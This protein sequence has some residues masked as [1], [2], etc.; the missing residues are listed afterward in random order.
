M[1]ASCVTASED[2]VLAE[3]IKTWWD[4]ESY[5]SRCDVSGRSKDDEKALQMLEQ[6]TKFDGERYEVGLLWKRRNP[7]LPNN[8]SSALN[9]MKSLEY[10]LERQPELKKLYQDTIKVDVEKGFV[11]ILK[12]E[13]LE[14]T[15]MERQWYVPHHPEE[16]PN[17]P[18]KV[19]RVCNAASKFR[20]ISLNDNLLTGTDLL[21]NLIG[22]IFRFREQKIA[23]TADIE[24]MFLQV[25]VQQEDCKVLRFLWRDN[26]NE[27][28]KVYEYG[29]H[30]F[31]AKSL[32]T[33]ANYALQQVARDYAQESPQIFKLIMRNFYKDDFVKSVPSA[34]QAIEI[35][36]LLPAML[37]KGGF[38][39]TKWIS[40]CEQTM[41]S[42]DQDDKSPASSKTFEAQPT[43]PSILGLQW[44]VDADNLEVCR[45]MQKE[46]P[47]KITQRAVLSHVS[48]LFDSLGIVSPFTIRMR[49]LLK[50][51]WKENRQSWVKELIEENRHEFKK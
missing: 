2:D 51:I 16:N 22:I 39:L 9:Q 18:G 4:I 14:A 48:A 47:V 46:I 40:N 8:Y 21:Q 13:E 41:T 26:P 49:L 27:P 30:I 11:R 36:K 43:S 5:A 50:S 45:R 44:N 10:R 19:R 24:A 33:C 1:T 17:K 28:F 6:T 23:I 3:Q 37:A 42:I 34:E 32:P 25:K 20:G 31:G 29:R 15:K 7:F 38:Q 12:Q 35:Y